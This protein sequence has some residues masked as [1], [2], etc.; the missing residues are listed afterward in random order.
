M[1]DCPFCGAACYCDG[2][3]LAQP[4][5]AACRHDCDNHDAEPDDDVPTLEDE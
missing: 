3:D 5:P 1:H 2:E 4:A